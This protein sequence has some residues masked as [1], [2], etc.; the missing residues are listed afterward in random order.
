MTFP[1][2]HSHHQDCCSDNQQTDLI[3][4]EPAIKEMDWPKYAALICGITILLTLVILQYI[5]S[6]KLSYTINV[7]VYAAAYLL[8]GWNV[9]FIGLRK[10]RRGDIFNE[11]VLMSVA[12]LGAFYIGEYTEGVAVM[13]F[14][15]VGELLQETAVNRAKRSIKALLDI[16]P[17]NVTVIRNGKAEIVMPV[18]VQV[19]EHIQIKPGE[20]L[21]LDGELRSAS[22]AF[23]TA[24]LT[25]ESRPSTK[26][27]G[28]QV[29]AGMIN[30]NTL[31]DVN[32]KALFKDSELSKI[33][34]MVQDA[35]AKKS[36]TQLFVSQFAKIYTPIVFFLA[37]AIIL[38][39]YFFVSEYHLND[40]LYRGLVFLVIS[41]PCALV[42]SIPLGYLGG[43]GLASSNGILFKGGNFLDAILKVD[44]VVLD[45]TGTLTEGVFI[46]QHIETPNSKTDELLQI[47]AALEKHTTHPIGKAIVSYAGVLSENFT[48]T[49][50]EEITGQGLKGR[51]NAQQV[52]VGNFKLMQKYRINYPLELKNQAGTTVVIA[53]NGQY[54][55]FITIA[56]QI[57]TD[58]KQA[59]H[60]L[61]QLQIRTILL[62]GDKQS[63]VNEVAQQLGIDTAY[64]ELLPEEKVQK[65]Q[66][67]K[68]GGFKIAFAGDGFNDAP[69]VALADVGIAMGGL[70]SEATIETADVV[71]Q[72]DDPAK[73][74]LAIHIGKITRNIVWQNIGMAMGVKLIVLALGAGGIAN[75]WEAVIAD[76][77]VALL[78]ILNAVRIQ[79]M[80]VD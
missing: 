1:K 32:V 20:R 23:N 55:G 77:G 45:K 74:S 80:R 30:L 15:S 10:I 9:L 63:V 21:A 60:Q 13:I 65:I 28:E 56:D 46:V 6:I 4:T 50:V 79:H 25:G 14:Y 31:I 69:A 47:V 53:I 18:E 73:I 40:W 3:N 64:G 8:S 75:L 59:I 2:T 27:Q 44:T 72:N 29:L 49:D 16:R 68:N 58:A 66:A 54:A 17:Q 22:A 39:P 48:T 42:V 62:S 37:L 33:L 51:V 7:L 24:A 71:I 26:Y 36:Q 67:L 76:V 12:T 35:S 5:F 57:K 19:N 41:C 78:A 70:G 61:H 38:L 34:E 11:F 52:L 43:I